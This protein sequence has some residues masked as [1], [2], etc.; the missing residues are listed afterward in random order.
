MS[1]YLR[2]RAKP[3]MERVLTPSLSII[4]PLTQ[5]ISKKVFFLF[6]SPFP[7]LDKRKD[8]GDSYLPRHFAKT[9]AKRKLA[10]QKQSV[11]PTVSQNWRL[12]WGQF[13]KVGCTLGIVHHI[14]F[15]C[16]ICML[17][18]CGLCIRVTIDPN[19]DLGT[20]FR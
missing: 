8:G 18:I 3:R 2:A 7:L 12:C 19:P 1:K 10:F 11:L 6:F 14:V 20:P 5:K 9:N 4:Y 15:N 16:L 13:F 17:Y